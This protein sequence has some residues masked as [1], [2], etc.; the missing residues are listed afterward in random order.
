MQHQDSA[1]YRASFPAGF[2]PLIDRLAERDYGKVL[3]GD[4]STVIFRSDFPPRPAPYFQA[5]SLVVDSVEGRSLEAA[6]RAFAARSGGG[7]AAAAL[8]RAAPS[9][10]VSGR[11]ASPSARRSVLRG[12]PRPVPK[13]A[14]LA[15]ERSVAAVTGLRP[16]SERPDLELQV[17]IRED[18]SAQFLAPARGERAD[19]RKR[20]ALPRSTARLLCELS[21][22]RGDDVFLDPFTGSGALPLERARMGDYAMIFAGDADAACMEAFKEALKAEE[23]ASAS[24]SRKRR[25]IFPKILDARDLSRFQPSFFTAIVTDPPWGLYEKLDEAA[26]L[27][28]YA[29]FLRE[30]DRVAAEGCRLVLLVGREAPLEEALARSGAAW[31][32]AEDY[33]VLVAGRKAR[34]LRLGKRPG[35]RSASRGAGVEDRR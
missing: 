30:A 29:D 2:R 13:D 19:D 34:A 21:A 14:R 15:L 11:R 10:A 18:G 5:L 26:L 27:G 17:S 25:T 9:P 12:S 32:I 28:L 35:E 7:A 24:F 31:A 23:R 3:G 6:Y 8:R 4:E 16:D 22:P 1:L 33:P 20:G